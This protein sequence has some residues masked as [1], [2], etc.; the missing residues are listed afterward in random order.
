MPF[1]L[2]S[3]VGLLGP[4]SSLFGECLR[5]EPEP[6]LDACGGLV[7]C[8]PRRNSTTRDGTGSGGTGPDGIRARRG[9]DGL[10]AGSDGACRSTPGLGPTVRTLIG[11]VL[12]RRI[13]IGAGTGA[14]TGTSILVATIVIGESVGGGG[15]A[16]KGMSSS[17]SAD[18]EAE[19]VGGRGLR[20]NAGPSPR[21]PAL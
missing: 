1:E 4:S 2:V 17:C 16:A 13:I 7:R 12:A 21:A 10:I 18:S 5:L 20:S 15:I 9:A 6:E 19:D 3:F 11:F 14:G 8:A